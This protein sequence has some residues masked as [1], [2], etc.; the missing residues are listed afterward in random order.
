LRIKEQATRP[1]LHEHDDDDDDDDDDIA[2]IDI[3]SAK[4]QRKYF[5][6]SKAKR[7]PRTHQTLRFT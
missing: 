1:A 6:F 5:C 3:I 7:V 4:I 2:D